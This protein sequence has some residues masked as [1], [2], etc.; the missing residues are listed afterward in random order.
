M[1]NVERF[2]NPSTLKWEAAEAIN[3]AQKVVV[4]EVL[5]VSIS[6]SLAKGPDGNDFIIDG[7]DCKGLEASK[8]LASAYPFH[9]YWSVDTDPHADFVEVSNGT[10]WVVI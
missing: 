3:G 6:G 2:W 10:I 9:T 4:V 8:P 7:T 1:A 5:N